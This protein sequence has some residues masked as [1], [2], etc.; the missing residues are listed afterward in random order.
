MSKKKVP[1]VPSLKA[2]DLARILRTVKY[3]HL[4]DCQFE[5]MIATC[6]R[7]K[8]DPWSDHLAITSR[9]GNTR[10]EIAVIMKITALRVIAK[11]TGDYGEQVG[12]FWCGADQVWH[13]AWTEAEPPAVAR[14]GVITRGSRRPFWGVANWRS[15]AQYT[16]EGG[17]PRLADFWARMPEFMLAKVAESQALR[18]AFPD[19]LSG[20]Y[21]PEEMGNQRH[22]EPVAVFGGPVVDGTTPENQSLFE[23]RL[24]SMYEMAN[25]AERAATI[26][27]YQAKYPELCMGE[28]R[29]PF[30]AAVLHDLAREQATAGAVG[31]S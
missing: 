14:V 29:R 4:T 8:L 12:P 11:R 22:I 25:T 31:A 19:E 10:N 28:D 26:R 20:I 27:R 9:P 6:Q 18:K 23:L 5:L 30:Y 1:G 15:F 2:E 13:R 21:I 16:T 17:E 3:A 7:L 24:V